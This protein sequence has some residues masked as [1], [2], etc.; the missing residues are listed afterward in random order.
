MKNYISKP[1]LIVACL[2]TIIAAAEI[3]FNAWAYSQIFAVIETKSMQ[4][5]TSYIII[6]LLGYI[7]FSI[8]G[9]LENFIIN[10]SIKETNQKIKTTILEKIILKGK[11]RNKNNV[12]DNLSFFLNDLKQLEDNYFLH[13]FK[14]LGYISTIILTL[15]FSIQNNFSLTIIFLLF[16]SITP[17]LTK[18]FKNKIELTNKL[19]T[20]KNSHFSSSLKDILQGITTLK[21]Y[22]AEKEYLK[23]FEEQTKSLEKSNETR[24]N[25]LALSNS[26]VTVIAYLFMYLPIGIGMAYVVQGKLP[27]SSFIAVQYSSS[28]IVNSFL[29][30]SQSLNTVNSTGDIRRKVESLLST[31][32]KPVT[33]KLR[34]NKIKTIE[35]K[36]V[37]F[38]YENKDIFNKLNFCINLGEKVLIQGPSGSGK[39]T[40]LKLITKEVV[41]TKGHIYINGEDIIKIETKELLENMAIVTQDVMIFNTSILENITLGKEFEKT[42]IEVAIKSAGLEDVVDHYGLDYQVGEEGQVLSGGQLKR[43]EIARAVLFNKPILLIDE[44]NA[45]LDEKTAIDINNMLSKLN[46]MVIDIEHYVPKLTL[47]NYDQRYVV[48]EENLVL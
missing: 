25:S 17:F 33:N 6:V 34:G 36:D 12:S 26:V 9:Y 47:P 39:S 20:T 41:P 27:L 46:K 19:W 7:F 15:L 11:I 31:K 30:L 37:S 13:L 24:K 14:S 22:N 5:I 8:I 1:H 21:N 42:E 10:K 4:Q 38:S 29:G 44:G 32:E 45:G 18:L 2:L 43:I 48:N 16:S 3:T 23:K 35:F 40:F 28:W